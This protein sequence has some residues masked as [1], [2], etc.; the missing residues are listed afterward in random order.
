MN[1]RYFFGDGINKL[2]NHILNHNYKLLTFIPNGRSV[3]LDLKRTGY[4]IEV[5]FDVGANIGQTA[6]SLRKTFSS[7]K[8]YCFEPVLNTYQQLIL[9]T[10]RFANIKCFPIALGEADGSMDIVESHNSELNSLKVASSSTKIKTIKV[11]IMSAL[12]FCETHGIDTIDILK[13]DVE[14][15]EHEVLNGFDPALLRN[16]IKFI[17]VEVGFDKADPFKTHYS[18]IDNYLTD[19]GF[20]LS[21]FYDPYRWGKQKLR[22]GFC[23]A[24]YCNSN[25]LGDNSST[26]N[27]A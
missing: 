24:L 10:S 7:A 1:I 26:R 8:I 25:I 12:S 4:P 21:G 19:M 13:I 16:N 11:K 22:L 17:Y 18:K 14:G 9:N 27:E 20:I 3:A 5:I 6:L 23:N 2:M 15:F